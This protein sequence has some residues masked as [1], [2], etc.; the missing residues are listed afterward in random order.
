MNK[1]AA[2]M[3]AAALSFAIAGC[4]D[5]TTPGS[6]SAASPP[7]ASVNTAPPAPS[8]AKPPANL[9]ILSVLS[10]EH[11]V[12]VGTQLD[13]VVV[14]V[15]KDEGSP[16]KE[17]EVM[18]QLD[19]RNLQ[20]EL[21]KAKDDLKVAQN[22]VLYKEAELKAKG[23]AYKRQ[24]QLREDGISSQADLEA[25]EFEAKAAEFDMK[26]WQAE[27]ESSQ[28]QIRQLELQID[29]TRLRAPFSGVIVRRYIRVGQIVGKNEKCFRVSQLAPLLV[30]FQV[31]ES[32]RRKPER[33]AAVPLALVD[34]S[35]RPLTAH[36]TRVSPTVDPASD[37]YDVTAQLGGPGLG[38][39]RPGMAVRVSWPG[40]VRSNP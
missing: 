1:P 35:S 2:W 14:S 17:G 19:D 26:G 28:A 23:A 37:S 36:I 33:G 11:Q 6:S 12:D 20:M 38:D 7:A 39:L 3:I 29:E 15:A 16:V 10:V 5:S 27:V 30:Q 4:G 40:T 8:P 34:A 31:P 13:G 9:E 32:S 21:V 22:N 18:G 24:K 25:A